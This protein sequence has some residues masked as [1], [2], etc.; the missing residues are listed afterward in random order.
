MANTKISAL[1]AATTPLA[2]TEVVPLNKS[3]VTSNVTVNNLTAGRTVNAASVVTTGNSGFGATPSNWNLGKAI[4]IGTV[5][6]GV[7]SASASDVRLVN[8]TYY[9]GGYLYGT[10]GTASILT[11]PNDGTL[12]FANAVSG[13]VNT[14]IPFIGRLIVDA[15]GNTTL[16][17]GNLV[18]GTAAKGINFTANTP[19]SG[20]TSQNLNWFETGTWTPNQ[21]SGLTVVGTFSSTG[22]YTRIGNLVTVQFKVS[23]STSVAVGNLGIISSNLPF[24]VSS[25]VSAVGTIT[26]LS[27]TSSAYAN[28]TTT[29]VYNSGSAI[30]ATG[31]I[32]VTVSYSI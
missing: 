28:S 22:I 13:S 27:I 5:G 7:W 10:T 26:T 1:S 29:N 11:M 14:S 21:G 19:Q 16:S 25:T 9:N 2:G 15:S 3:G 18:Q 12:Q 8:N 20:M 4:E 30:G 6:N 17:T 23:G 31:S 24:A 32:W